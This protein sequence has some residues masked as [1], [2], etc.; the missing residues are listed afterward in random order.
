MIYAPSLLA[1]NF[2]E[3]GSQCETL[4]KHHFNW[5]HYDVMDGYFVPNHSFGAII[6]SQIKA[7]YPFTCDVHLM[8]SSPAVFI[9]Y[10]KDL[11]DV[12]TIHIEAC[13]HMQEAMQ[14]CRLIRSYGIKAG[15]SIKPNTDVEAIVTLLAQVDLVLVMSVEPGFGGQRFIMDSLTKVRTLKALKEAHGYTYMIQI[16]GGI[17]SEN[18]MMVQAAGCE[19]CVVGSYMFA[20]F[21][22]RLQ[23]FL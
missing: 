22:S 21:P 1:A 14:L 3:L 19:N 8:V 13:A 11:A 2:L 7:K 4:L 9:E 17:T 12:I 23:E 6:L 16:D 18:A 10:Y 20:N 15:I 5:L